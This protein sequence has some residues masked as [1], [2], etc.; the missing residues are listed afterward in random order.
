M[1][2]CGPPEFQALRLGR[3]LMGAASRS[4]PGLVAAPD[5]LRSGLGMAGDRIADPEPG[6]FDGVFVHQVQ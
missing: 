6:P 5:D 2:I 4:T 1:H 3:P